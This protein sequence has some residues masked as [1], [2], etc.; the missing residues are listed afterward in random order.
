[1]LHD[2]GKIGIRDDVLNKQGKLTPEE[3]E[4][5]KEHP[6]RSYRVVQQVPQLA[7][8]LDGILYHHERYDGGGYPAGL[9][10]EAIPLQAR[11]I[12]IADVFDALTSSRSYRPAYS[13]EKAL[14]IMAQEAGMAV[15]PRLQKVF[16]GYIRQAMQAGPD[17]W[18]KL[19][20][21]A[22]EFTSTLASEDIPPQHTA[23]GGNS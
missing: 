6:E 17:A 15:D 9:K 12:Q 23:R 18:E 2:V 20:Q 14:S 21:R 4:H 3:F 7:K 22:N 13:W 10:G 5:I 8:A 19:V 16:D 11:I 1:L